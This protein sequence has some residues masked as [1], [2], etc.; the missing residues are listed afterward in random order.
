[1]DADRFQPVAE[2]ASTN[3]RSSRHPTV[4]DFTDLAAHRLL[5]AGLVAVLVVLAPVPFGSAHGWSLW[6]VQVTALVAFAL[7]IGFENRAALARFRPLARPVALLL[8]V[9]ALQLLPLPLEALRWLSPAAGTAYTAMVDSKARWFAASA[10]PHATIV[11]LVRLVALT[12]AFAVAAAAP[13]PGR[14][15]LF[16]WSILL[17]GGFAAALAWWHYAAGWDTRLFG[18]FDG[19]QAV[20]P[21][22]RLHWPLLNP[23]HLAAAMNVTW[24]L[25]LGAFIDPRLL[26]A[27]PIARETQAERSVALVVL[28]LAASASAFTYSRGGLSGALAG[29]SLLALLWPAGATSSKSYTVVVSV[30]VIA[31]TLLV[32]GAGWLVVK[33]STHPEHTT[34]LAAL[35]RQDATLQVRL[36]VVRQGLQM[37]RDFPWIG[38]GLGTWGETF[39]RYQRYPLLFATVSHAHSDPLEWLTDLGV[40]GFAALVWIGVMFVVE[41]RSNGDHSSR[42]RA[43]LLAAVGS[44]LVH[45]TGDFALRVP[46]VAIVAA[47]LLGMLWRERKANRPDALEAADS[48]PIRGADAAALAAVVLSLVYVAGWEW[49][50]E[51]LLA[52]LA[53][54][55]TISVPASADWR[56]TEALSRRLVATKESGLA[57][58]LDAVWSAPLAAR[59]HHALAYGYASDVMRERELRRTVACEPAMRFWRLEHAISLAALGRFPQARKEIEE[60]FYMDPQYGDEAWLRFQDPTDDTWPFLEAALRGV[61]R[62]QL[63]SP[64]IAS[65]VELFEGL[66]RMLAAAYERKKSHG[67]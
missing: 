29:L 62:R 50:D 67:R 19:Y 41:P 56:V 48:V 22:P 6:L 10:N 28:L 33:S 40:I 36:E 25:A 18:E 45:S 64:E 5:P 61:H 52:R 1:V 54:K 30:R 26:G 47:V 58:A 17:S 60:A 23:N 42:R 39:P 55:E 14:R 51:R 63:E 27:G 16:Y 44:L 8:G 9:V 12:G 57:P 38:T 13:L 59:A 34:V 65:Q 31:A 49:R 24:I 7:L 15:T 66:Q 21:M 43:V 37:L 4:D 32:L 3:F 35:Q 20:G 11:A 46:S 53:A 2:F